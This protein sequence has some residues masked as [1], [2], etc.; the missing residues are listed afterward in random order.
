MSDW[1]DDLTEM[2]AELDDAFG[3]AATLDGIP[4]RARIWNRSARTVETE[5]GH[6]RLVYAWA[7]IS[8]ASLA[9]RIP[10]GGKLVDSSNLEW[11]VRGTTSETPAS[12]T[13]DIY[14][15]D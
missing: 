4:V 3:D 5:T 7:T 11:T 10:R 13:Y 9:H 14:R 6:L 15:K 2:A 8:R 1:D 12:R